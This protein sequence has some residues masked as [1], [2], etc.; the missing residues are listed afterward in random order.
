[1]IFVCFHR[2]FHKKTLY[3]GNHHVT[4]IFANKIIGNKTYKQIDQ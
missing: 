1:M 4:E 3:Y 2:I